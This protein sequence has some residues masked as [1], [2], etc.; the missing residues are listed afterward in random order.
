[1]NNRLYL[2]CNH[3]V[4]LAIRRYSNSVWLMI[5]DN[6]NRQ[7]CYN[8]QRAVDTMH[9]L[10]ISHDITMSTDRGQLTP[11]TMQTQ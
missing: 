1:M 10:I 4:I 6:M 2:G 3:E 9:H 7:V 11:V 5:T 8:V